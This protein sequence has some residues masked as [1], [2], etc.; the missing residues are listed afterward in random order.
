[1]LIDLSSFILPPSSLHLIIQ[2]QPGLQLA[3]LKQGLL[4]YAPVQFIQAVGIDAIVR[5][6][7]CG[8]IRLLV[9]QAQ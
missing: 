6:P 7:A 8:A 3:C 1:M 2:R 9:T 5:L 4:E